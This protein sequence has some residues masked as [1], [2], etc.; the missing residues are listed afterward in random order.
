MRWISI[1]LLTALSIMLAGCAAQQGPTRHSKAVIET[2]KNFDLASQDDLIKKRS[3][4]DCH[5]RKCYD[6]EK[7][8]FYR[9][10]EA[11][12]DVCADKWAKELPLSVSRKEQEDYYYKV[13][14]CATKKFIKEYQDDLKPRSATDSKCCFDLRGWNE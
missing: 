14:S 7:H 2:A 6:M 13:F 10:L 8:E 5:W 9:K 1:A 3:P 4:N 12:T 11:K